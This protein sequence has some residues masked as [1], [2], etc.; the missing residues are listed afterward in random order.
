VGFPRLPTLKDARERP[1]IKCPGGGA[2]L[3][4]AIP[5]MK[6]EVLEFFRCHL[7]AVDPTIVWAYCERFIRSFIHNEAGV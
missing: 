6:Q 1:A 4:D 2:I 7:T 5:V 3:R